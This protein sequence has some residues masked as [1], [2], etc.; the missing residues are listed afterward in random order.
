MKFSSRT[1]LR[2]SHFERARRT[3]ELLEKRG[4]RRGLVE[5]VIPA[6][7]ELFFD[8]LREVP[9][10]D[11]LG[12]GEDLGAAVRSHG[13]HAPRLGEGVRPGKSAAKGSGAEAAELALGVPPFGEVHLAKAGDDEAELEQAVEV[14]VER[15]LRHRTHSVRLGDARMRAT[16]LR[17]RAINKRRGRGRAHG[18]GSGRGGGISPP[19]GASLS[20]AGESPSALGASPIAFRPPAAALAR[21]RRAVNPTRS[22]AKTRPTVH[23]H[24]ISTLRHRLDP[25]GRQH[26]DSGD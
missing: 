26:P 16:L 22:P 13:E 17:A 25:L 5:P 4:K 21:V 3:R 9:E 18:I 10:G 20:S 6:R 11:G 24:W 14:E 19:S 7:V 1:R 23:P 8:R 12:R 15:R 2:F